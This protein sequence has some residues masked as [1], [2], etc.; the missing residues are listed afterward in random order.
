M[1]EASPTLGV[2]CASSTKARGET[3]LPNPVGDAF[4]VDY[5][6]H[7][8]GHQFGGN[9]TFNG[10]TGSCGGGN[11]SAAHAN[12][13][14]SGSTIQ[15]YAGICQAENLQLHSDDYFTVES[16]NE[17]TQFITTGGGAACA[18]TAANGNT[19]PTVSAGSSFTIPIS[20]PFTLTASG[21][22]GNGDTLTYDWEER[23]FGTRH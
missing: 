16:L 1:A 17:M 23:D 7:E 10:T 11:R 3:G 19:V 18:A 6:A 13:V 21:S 2:V 4:D 22:D 20:T 5:V 9:H 12:E 8:M 15:A 14:G